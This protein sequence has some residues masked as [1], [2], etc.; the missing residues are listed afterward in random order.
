MSA[1]S[2]VIISWSRPIIA[3][4]NY[5]A[6]ASCLIPFTSVPGPEPTYR[7]VGYESAIGS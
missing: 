1:I 3:I 7:N 2:R 5:T 6:I 4:T